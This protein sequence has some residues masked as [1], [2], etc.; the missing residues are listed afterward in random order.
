VLAAISA[1][2]A[3]VALL[4]FQWWR[5]RK[6]LSYKVLS[7]VVL[8]SA[9]KEIED[10]VEIHFEGHS[11]KNVR[12]L[13]IKLINDGYQPIKKDD[14]EKS[15]EFVFPNAKILTA[16]KVKFFPDNLGTQMAYRDEK[17]EIDPA[18]FNRKDYIKFKVLVSGFKTLKVDA[19]IVGVSR[20]AELKTSSFKSTFAVLL[21]TAGFQ[22]GLIGLLK[23]T[24]DIWITTLS[25][26]V[27]GILS[28]SLAWY[29]LKDKKSG[30]E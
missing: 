21:F 30:E 18:L 16:E 25:V 28:A 26:T 4:Y 17:L 19:R 12:L 3:L 13:L 20:V 24:G 6:R 15:V 27:V 29:L 23:F 14:F 9:E 22:L 8:I 2:V 7:N 5:N 1:I 11:V 10:K